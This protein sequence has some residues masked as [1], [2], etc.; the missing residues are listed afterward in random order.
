MPVR[1]Y[2]SVEGFEDNWIEVT[3]AWTRTE[4]SAYGTLTGDQFIDLWKR[5][6]IGCHLTLGDGSLADDPALV[7]D[8]IGDFDERLIGLIR[9]GPVRAIRHLRTLGEVSVR[10]SSDGTDVAVRTS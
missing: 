3:D 5:K 7:Y 4:T 6:V 8:L 10:L 2:S 1:V 9:L